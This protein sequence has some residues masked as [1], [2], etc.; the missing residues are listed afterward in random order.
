MAAFAVAGVAL[1]GA[2]LALGNL[3]LWLYAQNVVTAAAQEAALVAS[4]EDGTA[5]DGQQ[6]AQALLAAGL[7]PGVEH[8]TNIDVS[9]DANAATA[10]VGGTWPVVLLGPAASAP[11]HATATIERERFRPGGN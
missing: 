11:L 1:V 4:R 5:Q 9:I 2:M 10:S 7:G 3:A 6:R 8:V